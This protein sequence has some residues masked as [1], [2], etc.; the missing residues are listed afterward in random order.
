MQILCYES[1]N[2]VA[3]YGNIEKGIY[4]ADPSRELYK[5]SNNEGSFY[6]VTGGLVFYDIDMDIPN[7]YKVGFYCYTPENGFFENPDYV[8]PEPSV[9]EK[10][11]NLEDYT[12]NLL[13]QVCLLQ[14]GMDGSEVEAS[15]K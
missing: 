4:P 10:V 15:N 7:D 5:I 3:F 2:A 13:Y 14:L 12:A 9:E 1:N 6:S 8:E 11:S